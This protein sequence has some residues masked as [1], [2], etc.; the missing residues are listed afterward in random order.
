VQQERELLATEYRLIKNRVKET[1]N[2]QNAE[3]ELRL[4]K[5]FREMDPEALTKYLNNNLRTNTDD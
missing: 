5:S 4:E 1:M 3:E 2:F